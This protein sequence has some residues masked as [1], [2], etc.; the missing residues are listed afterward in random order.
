MPF[1]RSADIFKR[2]SV[3]FRAQ[4]L[5]E[6][7]AKL[8]VLLVENSET[9]RRKL[10]HAAAFNCRVKVGLVGIQQICN[11]GTPGVNIEPLLIHKITGCLSRE[12]DL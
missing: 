5:K 9:F 1:F 2:Y 6:R 12:I 7:L 10:Y 8:F 11:N 3:G 4:L